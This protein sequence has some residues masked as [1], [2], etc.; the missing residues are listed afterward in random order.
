MT[1]ITLE[2]FQQKYKEQHPDA[3]KWEDLE[4]NKVHTIIKITFSA[5]MYGDNCIIT[6]SDNSNYWACPSLVKSLKQNQ[7]MP[8]YV[9]SLGLKQSNRS[10][11][12]FYS[13]SEES[14]HLE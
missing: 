14:D 11:N 1:T 10:S 2:Q 7:T 3:N 4:Q 12:M 6:L 13:F 8:K 5:G 9:V